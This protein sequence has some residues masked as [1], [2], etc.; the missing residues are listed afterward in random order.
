MFGDCRELALAA[1]SGPD[2][3]VCCMVRVGACCEIHLLAM[4]PGA[5]DVWSGTV[6][7]GW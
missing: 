5:S 6:V 1:W 4:P 3:D 7:D 2:V